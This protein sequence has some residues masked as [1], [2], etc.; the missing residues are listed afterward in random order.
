M[1]H[2]SGLGRASIQSL[3]PEN[4]VVVTA[5]GPVALYVTQ[6]GKVAATLFAL[7]SA[8]FENVFEAR[9]GPVLDLQAVGDS[10]KISNRQNFVEA[11]AVHGQ[12]SSNQERISWD[13]LGSVD[14]G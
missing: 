3:M 11:I 4:R 10:I 9:A 2:D 13:S 8:D 12:D 5:F 1:S 7:E 6:G 14:P